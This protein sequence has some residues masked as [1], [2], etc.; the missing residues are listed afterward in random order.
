MA[1][2][3]SIVGALRTV[4]TRTEVR[5]SRKSSKETRRNILLDFARQKTSL[6]DSS[7]AVNCHKNAALTLFDRI[8]LRK[9]IKL[10]EAIK[11]VNHLVFTELQFA[12]KKRQYSVNDSHAALN[13][14]LVELCRIETGTNAINSAEER[15]RE[16]TSHSNL[17]QTHLQIDLLCTILHDLEHNAMAF[18]ALIEWYWK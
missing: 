9:I 7:A 17:A 12:A 8:E 18:R 14:I 10:T 5:K 4:F 15:G 1:K 6:Y 3:V 11:S 2:I 16:A 13:A